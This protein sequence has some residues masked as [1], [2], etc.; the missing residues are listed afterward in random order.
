MPTV[1]FIDLP[2]KVY[3]VSKFDAEGYQTII[4]NA[5]NSFEQNLKSYRHEWRHRNDFGRDINVDQLEAERHTD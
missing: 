3:G 2:Y 1:V 5:K 4:L